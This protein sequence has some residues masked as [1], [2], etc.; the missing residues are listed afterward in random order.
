MTYPDGTLVDYLRDTQLQVK[1][2]GV[3]GGTRQVLL[4]NATYLPAGPASA[5]TYGNGRT[6]TRGYD[7]DY[8]A[9][10][11][12]DPGVGGLDIGYVYDSASYLKHG[13]T[14]Q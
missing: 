3:T 7:L 9:T 12:R 5:W 6:M 4:N 14:A 11:V 13:R 8:R 1:E 2:I 10:G